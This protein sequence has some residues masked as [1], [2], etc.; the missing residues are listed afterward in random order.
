MSTNATVLEPQQRRGG[1]ARDDGLVWSGPV[2]PYP[3]W[4]SSPAPTSALVTVMATTLGEAT[5]SVTDQMAAQALACSTDDV[6]PVMLAWVGDAEHE[7]TSARV[8]AY[9][10][11]LTQ[12]HVEG[13][14]LS[15]PVRF[16]RLSELCSGL[17]QRSGARLSRRL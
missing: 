1:D 4:S 9:V 2:L 16:G 17:R 7:A 8:T 12:G 5:P 3:R 10:P 6:Q 13:A 15:Q 14:V 11:A